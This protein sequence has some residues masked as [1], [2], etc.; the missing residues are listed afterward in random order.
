MALRIDVG[1]NTRAA[2]REVKDLSTAL[3]DTA[4]ALDDLA[5]DSKRAG[6]KTER[7]LDDIGDAGKDVGRDIDDAG[8]KVERTFREMVQDAKKAERAVDDVGEGGGKSMRKFGDATGEVM[9]E[10]RQNISETFSSFRGDAEDFAQLGQD[11]I[12]GLAGAGGIV[13]ALGL[14]AAAAGIGLLI[15][16]F[17]TLGEEEIARKERAAEW[18]AAYIDA[19][20]KIISHAHIVAAVQ[21]IATDP[22]KYKEASDNAKNWGVDVSTAMRAMAGDATALDIAQATLNEK[23]ERFSEVLKDSTMNAG[24]AGAAAGEYTDAEKKLADEVAA[25]TTAMAAQKAEMAAGADAADAVS[26]ALK[27]LIRDAGTATVKTDELGNEVYKLPDGTEILID[28]KTKQASLDLE[29]FKGD[30]DDVPDEKVSTVRINLDT[31][32]WDNWVPNPKTGRVG[33]AAVGWRQPV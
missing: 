30:L 25:G 5:R 28:A 12:G 18:A 17:E 31:S 3:D 21:D 20:D 26:N 33:T 14:G 11:I 23:Q 1:A 24:S 8:E 2:Q 13:G 6:D 16:Q 9:D 32:A 29:G 22:D 7:A 10:T 4:D 15:Q 19:G 27:D